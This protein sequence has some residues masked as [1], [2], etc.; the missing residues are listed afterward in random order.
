MFYGVIYSPV[1]RNNNLFEFTE[2]DKFIKTIGPREFLN[3]AI[4]LM[5]TLRFMAVP[6]LGW[7]VDTTYINYDLQ[8]LELRTSSEHG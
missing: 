1:F 8:T 5:Q 4:I 7:P 6:S 2:A 3:P